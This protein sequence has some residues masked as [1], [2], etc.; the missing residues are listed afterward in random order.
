MNLLQILMLLVGD[1]YCI[2]D[3]LKPA[4]DFKPDMPNRSFYADIQHSSL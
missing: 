3:Q 2:F 4:Y 1:L